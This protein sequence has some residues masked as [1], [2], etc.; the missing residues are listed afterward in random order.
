MTAARSRMDSL[1]RS[2]DSGSCACGSINSLNLK[3]YLE[4]ILHAAHLR[5]FSLSSKVANV[6]FVIKNEYFDS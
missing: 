3:K 5:L 4:Q 2:L 1:Q 6:D